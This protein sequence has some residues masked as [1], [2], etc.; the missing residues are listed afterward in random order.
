MQMVRGSVSGQDLPRLWNRTLRRWSMCLPKGLCASTMSFVSGCST[1]GSSNS[2]N[3]ILMNRLGAT[4]ITGIVLVLTLACS[5]GG[6][7]E[8]GGGTEVG[9]GAVTTAASAPAPTGPFVAFKD[10]QYEVGYKPGMVQPGKYR[11]TVPADSSC[12][13]ERQSNLS[14]DLGAILANANARAGTP[15]VLIIAVTDKGFKTVGCGEWRLSA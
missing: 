15:I 8:S 12:Y 11:T 3:E 5:S 7:G 14:G 6:S 9:T 13:W 1:G 4:S 10:G 2:G